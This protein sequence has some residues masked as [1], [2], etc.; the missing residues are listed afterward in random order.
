MTGAPTWEFWIDRGGT[1]TDCLGLAPDG[2][3]HTAKLLSSDTA[4][5]EGFDLF[6]AAGVPFAA[7]EPLVRAVVDNAFAIG[8]RA[9][10]TGPVARGDVGTVAAQRA[11][12]AEQAPEW[13]E[14][15]VSAATALASLTGRR[16]QFE[17]V[18]G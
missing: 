17:D 12:I 3:L 2:A 8:P 4:P 5:V 1:F 10:L 14:A 7:A 13:E 6:D 9:A 11:A 16:E 18:L 15:F